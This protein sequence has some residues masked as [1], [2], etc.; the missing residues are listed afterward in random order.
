MHVS[1]LSPHPEPTSLMAKALVRVSCTL[2][3]E[4]KVMDMGGVGVEE[5]HCSTYIALLKQVGVIPAVVEQP[6]PRVPRITKKAEIDVGIGSCTFKFP[7]AHSHA[8]PGHWQAQKGTPLVGSPLI[9]TLGLL[10]PTSGSSRLLF[11]TQVPS[12]LTQPLPQLPHTSQGP[13]IGT[14]LVPDRPDLPDPG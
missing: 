7:C 11:S 13:P 12:G 2:I 10:L 5:A 9:P 1:S 14:S 6:L 4:D 8:V 3:R